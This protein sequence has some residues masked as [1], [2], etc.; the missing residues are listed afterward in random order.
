MS[1]RAVPLEPSHWYLPDATFTAPL[2]RRLRGLIV[3]DK[4]SNI[5]LKYKIIRCPLSTLILG[6]LHGIFTLSIC[7]CEAELR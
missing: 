2:Q 1:L 6:S 3:H 4:M 7:R 5:R